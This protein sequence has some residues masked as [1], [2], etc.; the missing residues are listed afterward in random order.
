MVLQDLINHSAFKKFSTKV[1]RGS[2]EVF[3]ILVAASP[4]GEEVELSLDQIVKRATYS[5]PKVVECLKHLEK[6]GLIKRT[7]GEKEGRTQVYT[8]LRGRAL[9]QVMK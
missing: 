9:T 3:L 8:L 6:A 2:F 1:C 5:Q 4:D 7:I